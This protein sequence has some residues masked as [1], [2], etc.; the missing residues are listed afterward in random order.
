MS[1]RPQVSIR[2]Y[3]TDIDGN[4]TTINY[5]EMGDI[6]TAQVMEGIGKI[7]DTFEFEIPFYKF[8]DGT[9]DIK[10]FN[11]PS[12]ETFG[13][14]VI[15]VNDVVAIYAGYTNSND[16][17]TDNLLLFGVVKSFAITD[18][19]SKMRI[20][21]Q[22]ANRTEEMLKGFVPYTTYKS[23]AETTDTVTGIIKAIINRLNTHNKKH[24]VYGALTTETVTITGTAGGI[25][26][27]KRDGVTTFPQVSYNATWKPVHTQIEELSSSGYTDDKDAGNYIFYVESTPVLSQYQLLAPDGTRPGPFVDVLFWQSAS[28]VNQGTLIAGSHFGDCTLSYDI[29]DIINALI[30][31]AGTDKYGN[32]VITVAYDIE[33]MSKFGTRWGYYTQSRKKFSDIEAREVNL[34]VAAGEVFNST[35]KFPATA[36]YP[37]TMKVSG[38]VVADETAYNT[39]LRSIARAEAREE[40]LN[41]I[42][43]VK[44]ARYDITFDLAVGS[45]N[46]SAGDVY[47]FQ[48]PTIGWEGTD[49]NPNHLLRINDITHVLNVQGW[50]TRITAKEDEEVIRLQLQ[51]KK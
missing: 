1:L 35:T 42:R 23:G 48:I 30:V 40:A 5:T 49:L 34:G 22:G 28:I 44:T 11:R 13:A 37:Y 26:A 27:K 21:V 45:N 43:K 9:S 20:R 25:Q 8:Y 41:V 38:T 17:T 39:E 33:S 12:V 31:N 10:Y 24:P 15:N 16:F 4:I 7:K 6:A 47:A 46:V 36:E 18:S 14:R 50:S 32:G 29:R 2:V 19:G 51:G 3:P